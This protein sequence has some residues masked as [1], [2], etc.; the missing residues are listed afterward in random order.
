MAC[1]RHRR[2]PQA[3][4]PGDCGCGGWDVRNQEGCAAWQSVQLCAPHP[5]LSGGKL[6]N[7]GVIEDFLLRHKK[8]AFLSLVPLLRPATCPRNSLVHQGTRRKSGSGFAGELVW[9]LHRLASQV[10][11][12]RDS[13][14]IIW[15]VLATGVRPRRAPLGTAGVAGGTS[16]TR[17]GAPHGRACSFARLTLR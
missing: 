16:E 17:R 14:L 4:A 10:W 5:A 11:C 7:R 6:T 3:C 15:H 2:A 13:V 9:L 12:D 8:T 1:A